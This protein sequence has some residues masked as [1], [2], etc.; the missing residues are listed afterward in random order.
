MSKPLLS[1][2][3][4]PSV[5]CYENSVILHEVLGRLILGQRDNAPPR[6]P[7]RMELHDQPNLTLCSDNFP[8]T[9]GISD[10]EQLILAELLRLQL[11]F[12]Q[13]DSDV[14]TRPFIIKISE[15][16]H[17]NDKRS[18]NCYCERFHQ[19]IL[20]FEFFDASPDPCH[21]RPGDGV[22]PSM[23]NASTNRGRAHLRLRIGCQ[24]STSFLT[25]LLPWP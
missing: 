8:T 21:A 23:P 24:S 18:D 5:S 6:V 4:P 22:T 11:D 19:G 3:L 9:Q 10:D 25:W 16:S 20:Q 7:R 14:V 1:C 17:R 2:A 13:S 15:H 12:G